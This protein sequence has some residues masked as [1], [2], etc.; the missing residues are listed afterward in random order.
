MPDPE[1][2]LNGRDREDGPVEVD[3]I[4]VEFKVLFERP[5]CEIKKYSQAEPVI[6][7]G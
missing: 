6:T 1:L 2:W 7:G 5:L 3:P 4:A